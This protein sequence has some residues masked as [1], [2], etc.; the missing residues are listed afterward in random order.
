MLEI[1]RVLSIEY[2]YCCNGFRIDQAAIYIIRG[3]KND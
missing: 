2:I 1:V 3:S